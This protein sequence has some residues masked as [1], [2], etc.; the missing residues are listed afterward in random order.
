MRLARSLEMKG[1]AIWIDDHKLSPGDHIMNTID[2]AI[3]NKCDVF[4]FVMS[5]EFWK[6]TNCMSELEQALKQQENHGMPII[7]IMFE[8]CEIPKRFVEIGQLMYADFQNPGYFDA[9]VDHLIKGVEKITRFQRLLSILQ[10]SNVE[11]QQMRAAKALAKLGDTAAVPH[12]TQ[13]LLQEKNPLVRGL[14]AVA[15]GGIGTRKGIDALISAM[16]DTDNWV[17]LMVTD[18]L[19]S[20]CREAF[21]FVIQAAESA[22]PIVRAGA[23]KVLCNTGRGNSD[24]M[25]VIR[26]LR[27]DSTREVQ[28]A[29]KMYGENIQ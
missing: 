14:C 16:E 6:S 26:R 23:V 8:R 2:R 15:L 19:E 17:R 18:A 27:T 24:I 9:A 12:L 3:Q 4:L 5:E 20:Q 21:T 22:N 10:Y 7:P 1:L 25:T 29:L 28:C 11:Q 13:V